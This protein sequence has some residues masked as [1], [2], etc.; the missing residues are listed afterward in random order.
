MF[1]IGLG[2]NASYA[3]DY[4]LLRRLA[5]DPDQ[6][7][8]NTPSLYDVCSE[9]PSCVTYANQPQGTFIWSSDQTVLSSAFMEL[10]SQILRL[11]R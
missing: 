9:T 6:D 11:S 7:R 2:G 8:F 10:S 5:N 4:T 3:P 1:V